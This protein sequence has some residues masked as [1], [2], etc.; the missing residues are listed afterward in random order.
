MRISTAFSQS[1]NLSALLNQQSR[2]N[3]TQLQLSSG[4]RISKPSD[5][6]AG[7]AKIINV[8]QQI[9]QLEQYQTNIGAAQQRLELEDST[10]KTANEAVQRL[11]EIATQSLNDIN[12]ANNRKT[13]AEEVDQLSN[14]LLA[15]ANTRS[16]NGEYLFAGFKSSTPPF[17]ASGNA[18][19]PFFSYNG[20]TNQR[21]IQISETRT[22]ADGDPG[23]TIFGPSTAGGSDSIFDVL[24]QFSDELKANSPQ[25][26]ILDKLKT[27][28]NQVSAAQSSVGVRLNALDS[29]QTANADFILNAQTVLSNTQDLDY[30]EAIS[31]YN[32]QTTALQAAQQTFSR[33]QRLTLF[34]EL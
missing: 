5:D 21:L 11:Q 25:V 22:I 24:R 6:P 2:L 14:Q 31:R 12:N 8:S 18:T 27:A 29:Q 20:D 15:L 34:S 19:A 32:L 1:Q 13:L 10:L 26:G 9:D 3:D 23:S 33:V 7:A 17:A 30:A 16:A 4:Q 28:L